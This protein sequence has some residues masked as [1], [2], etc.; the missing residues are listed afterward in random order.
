[1]WK[2]MVTRAADTGHSI[3]SKRYLEVKYEDFVTSPN[4]VGKRITEFLEL[5]PNRRFFASLRNARVSS[6]GISQKRQPER[7]FQEANSVAG[8]TLARFGYEL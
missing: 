8:E 1:M 7:K 3:G 5:T 4:S 2:E 6:I